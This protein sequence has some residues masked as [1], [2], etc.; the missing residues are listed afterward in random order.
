MG[1]T[2]VRIFAV[3]VTLLALVG[4]IAGEGHLLGFMNIDITLDILRVVLA[5][6]LL[7][8]G[9]FSSS[10]QSLR[11]ALWVFT[12]LYLGLGLLG[13]IS[14]TLWGLLPSGLTAFDA[15]FHLGAGAIALVAVLR[16]KDG[17]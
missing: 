12:I 13:L 16:M 17:E 2:F 15:I 1:K 9:F 11:V 8:A 4:L 7:Y 5:G 10:T 14:P 6:L 3:I